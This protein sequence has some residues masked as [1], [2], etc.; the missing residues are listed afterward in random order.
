MRKLLVLS[1]CVLTAVLLMASNVTI[2]FWTL[3][4]SPAFDDYIKA[5]IKDFETQNPGIKVEWVDIPYGSAVEK[6]TAAVA[7]RKAPDVVNL[8]TSWAIDFAAMGALRPLDDLI[9]AKEKALYWEK[10]WNGTVI[11]GKSYAFP[12]YASIPIMMYNTELFRKAGLDPTKPPTTWNEVFVASRIFRSKLA[13][14]GFVPNIIALD[15]LLLE[16]I[17]ILSPDKKKAAFNT[18]EAVKK[19][20]FF[21]KA[22]RENLMTRT[23]G[24]YAEGRELFQAGKLAMYPAGLTMLKH[25]ELNSPNVFKVTD[26]APYPVGKAGIIKVSLMNLV[27]PITTK[28]PKEATKFALHVTSPKWQIEFSKY[29]TVVPSTRQGLESSEEFMKRVKE[30]DLNA[31]AML[32]ASKSMSKAVDLNS[33]VVHGIPADKYASVRKIIQDYW[34]KAIKGEMT[35]Q[36]ALSK[37]EAE[38]N[39]LLK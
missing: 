16:G 9:T 38:V 7:A 11:D 20:E 39:N 17:P 30:G 28:Y 31:K 4:L 15:E 12:W 35:A 24:G 26:V 14:Y 25:I 29:A 37:A 19:L 33:V 27:I 10:L 18:P 13:V 1:M 3:S 22:Y 8:N 2:E 6:L 32:M 5:I 34:M 23:L 21:Q 36:E